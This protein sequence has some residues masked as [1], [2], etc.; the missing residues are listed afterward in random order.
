MAMREGRV[1]A[2]G[3]PHEVVTEHTVRSVFGLE[4]RVVTDPVSRTPLVVPVGRHHPQ[5]KS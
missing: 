3:S 4:C 5:E 1:V 2:D